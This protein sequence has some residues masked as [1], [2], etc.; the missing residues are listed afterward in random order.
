MSITSLS[1][2]SLAQYEYN[3]WFWHGDNTTNFLQQY[4]FKFPIYKNNPVV[5]NLLWQNINN[6]FV[7]GDDAY[8]SIS[9]NNS[10]II[11]FTNGLWTWDKN[12]N[13][14]LDN[15]HFTNRIN[16]LNDTSYILSTNY[17]TNNYT[18]SIIIK[19]PG[20]EN[21]YYVFFT[22]IT[23]RGNSKFIGRMF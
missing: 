13:L 3:T 15:T 20:C 11:F 22:Y 10:N 9:D 23:E 2:D 4:Y 6:K 19:K 17:L 1:I 21:I 14:I 12:I 7:A 16:H 8:S 18:S 5:E